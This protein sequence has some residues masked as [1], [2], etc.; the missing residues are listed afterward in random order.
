MKKVSFPSAC[1]TCAP[2]EG[3]VKNSKWQNSTKDKSQSCEIIVPLKLKV[4]FH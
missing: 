1:G 3:H 4:L 2:L